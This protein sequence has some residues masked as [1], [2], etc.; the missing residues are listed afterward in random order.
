MY[1][2]ALNDTL[3]PLEHTATIK[4][5]GAIFLPII[6]LSF[7]GFLTRGEDFG[8]ALFYTMIGTFLFLSGIGRLYS[9]VILWLDGV[10][11]AVRS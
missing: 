11:N 9:F 10:S 4:R 1:F 8:E 5:L 3:T 2:V 6:V 7:L